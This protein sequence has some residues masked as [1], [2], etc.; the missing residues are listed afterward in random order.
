[1]SARILLLED[2]VSLSEILCEFLE[3]GGYALTHCEDATSAL[4]LAYERQFD[5]WIFDAKV[6]SGA[7]FEPDSGAGFA[8][9]FGANFGVGG[10]NLSNGFVLLRRLREAGKTTPCIFITA[11]SAITDVS[12]GYGVGCDDFLRKPFELEEL[13]LRIKTLLKRTFKSRISEFY[14]LGG[15]LSFN[16]VNKI[17]YRDGAIVPLTQK[18]R[19]LLNLLLQ[20]EGEFV[21]QE[22]I[23]EEL[24]ELERTPSSEA[25]RVYVKNLRKIIGRDKILN[26]H[27]KGYC[28]VGKNG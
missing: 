21:L 15:G 9:N 4:D 20:N 11:L 7:D 6:P 23:F 25:L 10:G 22:K 13:D 16:L 17:L 2:D 24:W 28:Y 3:A 14:E 12:A 1:M 19:Q 27:A 8:S 26:S 5:L 18:E